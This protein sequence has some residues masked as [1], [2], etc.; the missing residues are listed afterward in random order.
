MA[1]NSLGYAVLF[2][3]PVAC[4]IGIFTLVAIIGYA[5]E[6]RRERESLYR[7]ETARKLIEQGQMSFEQF[8][9]YERA[10]A[11]RPLAA[12]RRGLAL[13]GSVLGVTGLAFFAALNQ[14]P[15]EAAPG[16]RELAPLGY[17]PMGIGAA[18]LVHAAWPRRKHPE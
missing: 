15:S 6:R 5:R 12:R 14:I 1:Q 11:L 7:H 4:I 3:M 10:E 8:A 13:I 18:F 17:I 2:L 16:L 9:A